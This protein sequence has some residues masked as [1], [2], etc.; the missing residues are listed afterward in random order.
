MRLLADS[1][2]A[3]QL[4]LS[5][6]IVLQLW[7]LV[8]RTE[9]KEMC[10]P[11]HGVAGQNAIR[12]EDAAH[13][14]VWHVLMAFHLD[15]RGCTAGPERGQRGSRGA[16]SGLEAPAEQDNRAAVSKPFGE[17]VSVRGCVK[18]RPKGAWLL[19]HTNNGASRI[20]RCS[21]ISVSAQ[22]YGV[23]L[24][25]AGSPHTATGA[26]RVFDEWREDLIG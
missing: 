1:C 14:W 8:G 16:A 22:K 7:K 25:P 4:L 18:S 9:Q 6:H 26:A 10:S 12:G 5:C 2:S 11:K 15:K 23:S 20:Y 17:C 13:N 19:P 3:V 21:C 24:K